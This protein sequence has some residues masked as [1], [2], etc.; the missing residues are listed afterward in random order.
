M[1]S[2]DGSVR[3]SAMRKDLDDYESGGDVAILSRERLLD[4][5]SV[6]FGNSK[7]ARESGLAPRLL[8]VLQSGPSYNQTD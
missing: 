7:A 8:F 4:N 1:N 5:L 3:S 6:G 2:M